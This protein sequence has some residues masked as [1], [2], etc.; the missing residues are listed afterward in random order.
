[1]IIVKRHLKNSAFPLSSFHSPKTSHIQSILQGRGVRDVF[2]DATPFAGVWI[3]R[4]ISLVFW[5]I[6]IPSI[7]FLVVVAFTVG[8]ASLES[9]GYVT[10]EACSAK[11]RIFISNLVV[12]HVQ[13]E[14]T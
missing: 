9:V 8:D 6:W 5:K 10:I 1:M 2:R 7:V 13:Y 12:R 3:L 11:L 4:M 14:A